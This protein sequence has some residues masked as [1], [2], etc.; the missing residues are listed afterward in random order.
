[1]MYDSFQLMPN[2]FNRILIR[3]RGRVW[4]EWDMMV[5]EPLQCQFAS[6]AEGT[7]LLK[8][9]MLPLLI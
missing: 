7:I 1:M 8:L 2:G 3:Q 4:E 5:S 9:D 6:V